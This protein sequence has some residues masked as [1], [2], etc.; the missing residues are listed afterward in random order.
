MSTPVLICDDSSFAR[1]Q[2]AR[3]LPPDWD[4][5][6]SFAGNGQEGLEAVRAGKAD[7]LFLDLNMPVMDGF[8]VLQAIRAEDLPSMVIVVSG[9]I[10][11][12]AHSRVMGLGALAFIK[13]PVD[14]NAV[15]EIL[16]SYGLQTDTSASQGPPEVEVDL[17][18]GYQEIAN[19]AMGRAADLLA[20]LLGGFVEMPIP[21]VNMIARSELRMALSQVDD[22]ASV[23]AVCQGFIGGGIA[24][25]ALLVFNQSSFSDIAELMKYKGEMSD[26]V[27]LE[28]LMDTA[29]IVI[30]ACLK[31]I[32]DQLEF[33]LSQGHPVVLGRQVKVGAL[34]NG[35]AGQWQQTL[36]VEMGCAIE[37]RNINADL[38]LLFT[39]DSMDALN[40]RI[41]FLMD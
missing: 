8:E 35:D 39:E 9:D 18:E 34:L 3:A 27:E 12:E 25:E 11:P 37:G 22:S 38:L 30:G 33:T 29:N 17:R 6:I 4:V 13:K 20:R 41:G 21:K 40:Q 2:M 26:A 31:G 7:I 15:I 19:V 10:Q 1:K 5:E 24:G 23:S 28:L 16:K 32:A 14:V 36:A